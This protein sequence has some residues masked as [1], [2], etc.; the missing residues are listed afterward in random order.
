[1][2]PVWTDLAAGYIFVFAIVIGL[3]L[4]FL[5]VTLLHGLMRMTREEISEML[6]PRDVTKQPAQP[7]PSPQR[8]RVPAARTRIH[9][10]I[11]NFGNTA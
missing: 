2:Q 9:T 11:R 10:R 3:P 4:I 6:T 8:K 5:I 7:M 1:M